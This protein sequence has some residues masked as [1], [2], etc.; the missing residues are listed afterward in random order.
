MNDAPCTC[1]WSTVSTT[2][3]CPPHIIKIDPDCPR[4][5]HEAPPEDSIVATV[6]R[7]AV[8]LDD[9]AIEL[10]NLAARPVGGPAGRP[11]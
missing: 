3:I 9:V 10:E 1:R 2:T 4:H 5:G 11:R 7:L 6:E 8:W